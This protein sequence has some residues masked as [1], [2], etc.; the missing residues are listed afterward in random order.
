MFFYD[1]IFNYYFF[2]NLDNYGQV[3]IEDF[4]ETIRIR[5]RTMIKQNDRYEEENSDV[6]QSSSK[7]YGNND[8][9]ND[10]FF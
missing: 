9:D 2:L 6:S 1:L 10:D 3:M 7:E 5:K 8:D 4:E